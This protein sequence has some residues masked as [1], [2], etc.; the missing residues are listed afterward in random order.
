MD[1]SI[2]ASTLGLSKIASP[3][4]LAAGFLLNY[5]DLIGAPGAHENMR[6]VKRGGKKKF[7]TLTYKQ[8]L[9][10]YPVYGAWIQMVIKASTRGPL[11]LKSFSGKYLPEYGINLA[12]PVLTALE[13]QEIVMK[14]NKMQTLQDLWQPVPPKLWILDMALLAPRCPQCETVTH[15]PRLA[16]RVIFSAP[17]A[18]GALA[19]AFVDARDGTVLLHRPRLYFIDIDIEDALDHG[20]TNCWIFDDSDALFD[21]DGLC[22]SWPHCDCRYNVCAD[23]WSCASPDAENWSLWRAT[24]DIYRFYRDAL[25]R[26]SYDGEGE[27]FEMYSHVN[28]EEMSNSNPQAASIQCVYSSIHAFSRG[29]V[30]RDVVGHEV[31]HSFHRKEAT[32]EY[33]YESGAVAEH[34]ADVMGVF[35]ASWPGSIETPVDNDWLMGEDSLLGSGSPCGA[36]RDLSDPPRCGHPD[37]YVNYLITTS[38]LGGVHTNCGIPNKAAYLMTMGGTHRGIT[39]AGIGEQ[40]SRSIYYKAIT[41][42]LVSNESFMDLAHHLVDSCTELI[43]RNGIRSSDCCQVRNAFAAVG[44]ISSDLDCDGIEDNL[45]PDD[46]NDGIPDSRDNC[47]TVFNPLQRDTD[48]DGLGDSCDPD[49]DNDG[50]PNESDNCPLVSNPAQEDSDAN[51]IGDA[52]QDTDRDG[53]LDIHDNCPLAYN[54]DQTDT[55]GDGLGDACDPDMDGDGIPNNVDNCPR[56]ANPDQVDSD[57]DGLGDLCD[58]C[59]HVSNP[60]Q[61]DMDH[62]GIGDHCDEDRDG[63]GIMNGVDRCPDIPLLCPVYGQEF[64]DMALA[65]EEIAHMPIFVRAF[66]PCEFFLCPGDREL[67]AENEFM[68]IELRLELVLPEG[69]VLQKPLS[70]Y[71]G[72]MDESGNQLSSRKVNFSEG[73]PQQSFTLSVKM[74]PSFTWDRIQ[75]KGWQSPL[76]K[77]D[78]AARS[79]YFFTVAPITRG[80]NMISILKQANLLVT[81]KVQLGKK[82]NV[83]GPCPKTVASWKAN[84]SIW[85]LNSM[86]LGTHT[87]EK[88]ELMEILV[89]PIRKDASLELARELIA[90]KLNLG[91]GVSSQMI[92]EQIVWGDNQLSPFQNKLPYFIDKE[93][94]MGKEM[95]QTA[96]L[97]RSFNRGKLSSDCKKARRQGAVNSP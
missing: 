66:D 50:I 7:K 31:G 38:D 9:A 85:P 1:F 33:S 92:I 89:S 2:T 37:R 55:D 15:D 51:G 67:F 29:M 56:I 36:I 58:N 24:I 78:D 79:S 23:G 97:L 17:S 40:K 27:E 22:C 5:S 80:Q 88:S 74:L 30:T 35:A 77:S 91:M 61:Q 83:G 59:I 53:I 65:F 3:E 86:I 49:A 20:S 32:Y 52:C 48:G 14:L 41:E 95:T 10:G 87:Y 19:E 43:G 21:E 96:A 6:L 93:I 82:I 42:K 90:A 81:S 25:E 44:T 64:I 63:D 62:D 34:I 69:T 73:T 16:W 71:F 4:E 54:P 26:D 57:G 84:Q 12:E 72:I 70:F 8:F 68:N 94:E 75:P 13:A 76:E 11:I 45:D 46:D 39:V 28:F 18:G 60:R 47:P